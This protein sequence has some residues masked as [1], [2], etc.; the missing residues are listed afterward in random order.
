MAEFKPAFLI[1][2]NHEMGYVDHPND[3]GG[4]TYRGITRRSHGAWDGWSIIDGYK[5]HADFLNRLETDPHLPNLVNAL[6]KTNY[7]DPMML[8]DVV[9]QK[10]A[11]ELFDTSINMGRKTAAKF[12]QQALNLLNRNEKS[13]PDLVEDGI[14][15]FRTITALNKYRNE[16]AM[17]KTLNGLQFCKYRNICENDKSQE[18]FFHGWLKRV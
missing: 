11:N 16:A 2:M 10:I 17:I 3:R 18:V 6:Y 15:G 7:W 4:E 13:F 1:S 8:D 14:A 9:N 12:L 5:D